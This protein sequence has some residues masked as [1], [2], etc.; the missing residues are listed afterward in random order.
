MDRI[1]SLKPYF[2]ISDMNSRQKVIIIGSY[3]LS[4]IIIL[5]F[6][7]ARG[8]YDYNSYL[9]AGWALREGEP[10]AIY[11]SID[12]PNS[13]GNYYIINNNK[14]WQSIVDRDLK[15]NTSVPAYLYPPPCAVLFISF[16]YIN[17]IIGI[18]AW[19]FLCLIAYMLGIILLLSLLQINI[20][21]VVFHILFVLTIISPPILF[22]LDL[23]QLTPLIFLSI[24]GGL[25]FISNDYQN[26]S[27]ICLAIGTVLKITPIIFM[28]WLIARKKYKAI[29][30]YCIS[31]LLIGLITIPITGFNLNLD[32][33]H[34]VIPILS[35]YVP[36]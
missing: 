28:P 30:S 10:S 2:K 20:N 25:W 3:C 11:S 5:Y 15:K 24:A 13:N 8:P 29:K 19:R 33:I 27:G 31:I 9:V 23:G 7:L 14:S 36:I 4:S 16:T 22:A 34:H 12:T 32:Y 17:R 26:E 6:M 21:K 18:L 1:K 35:P